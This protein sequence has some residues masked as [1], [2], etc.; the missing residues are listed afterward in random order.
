MRTLAVILLLTVPEIAAAQVD[1]HTSM[2]EATGRASAAHSHDNSAITVNPAAIGLSQRYTMEA[3]AGYWNGKDWRAGITAMDSTNPIAFGLAYERYHRRTTLS[4]DEL[5]G[6]LADGE[7][8]PKQR[9]YDNIT[10]AVA[11]PL[12]DNRLSFGVNGTLLVYSHSILGKGTTG[13]LDLGVAGRPTNEWSVGVSLRNV[14]P[15]YFATDKQTGVLAGTRYAWN[16][17]TSVMLDVDVPLQSSDAKVPVAVRGG[18]EAGGPTWQA[19]MG[20]R[21][22]GPDNEHWITWGAGLWSDPE[23]SP[24]GGSRAAFHYAMA[25][26]L[27]SMGD[28]TSRLAATTHTISIVIAP[29]VR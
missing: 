27:H 17:V 16:E 4:V 3:H 13:D 29:K 6:W 20:Y 21:F 28:E 23:T 19:G 10:A 26:P 2:V 8:V 11:L 9:R 25:I 12:L 15:V 24:D 7:E 18:F 1:V 14:L 5:P 22:E